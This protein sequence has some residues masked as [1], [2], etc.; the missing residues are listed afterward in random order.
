MLQHYK[1]RAIV[2]FILILCALCGGHYLFFQFA[3]YP[4]NPFPI[5]RGLAFGSFLFSTVLWVAML[6]N[7]GWARY[8][9]NIWLGIAIFAFGLAMLV[10]NTRS[11]E[12]L[13]V[14]TKQV[15]LGMALYALAMT[16]LSASRSVRRYLAPRT[17]GGH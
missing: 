17:A 8:V 5:T 11:V 12:P 10:M 14:P 1:T 16:P 9:L 4:M 6:L 3:F 7:K 2:W 13:P 15:I